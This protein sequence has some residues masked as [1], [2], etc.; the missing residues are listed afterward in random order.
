MK[1]AEP[2]LRLAL[3]FFATLGNQFFGEYPFGGNELARALLN[4]ADPR[5]LRLNSQNAVLEGHDN[6]VS[7]LKA[8]GFADHG[9]N[10]DAA[11]LIDPSLNAFHFHRNPPINDI[12]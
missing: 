2:L 6:A 12:I 7:Q 9:G 8:H 10:D 4:A 5:L 1:L 11:V 3:R